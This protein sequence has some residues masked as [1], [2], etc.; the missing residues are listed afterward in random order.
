MLRTVRAVLRDLDRE[1]PIANAQSM[2]DV[3]TRSVSDQRFVSSLMGVFSI[4]ALAL[5]A[6]GIYG[7]MA[8]SVARRTREIGLRMAL[9]ATRSSVLGSVLRGAVS[10]TGAGIGIGVVLALLLTRVVRSLVFEVDVRDPMVF[11]G[12]PLMLLFVALIAAYLPAR[13]AATVAPA[14]AIRVE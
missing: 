10:L 3:V 14:E 2:A 8:Y 12:A 1:L 9:G 5:G 13:R 7:V 11:V 4:L 6:V